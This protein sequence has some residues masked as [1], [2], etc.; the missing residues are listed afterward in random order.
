MRARK[1]QSKTYLYTALLFFLVA[2]AILGLLI[3]KE[4]TGYDVF[5]PYSISGNAFSGEAGRIYEMNIKATY[6]PHWAGVPGRALRDEGGGTLFYTRTLNRSEIIPK[7][8]YTFECLISPS[9]GEREMYASFIQNP[10]WATLV[11]AD[12]ALV[13]A[14]LPDEVGTGNATESANHTFNDTSMSVT[15]GTRTVN[16]IPTVYTYVNNSPDN[17]S[18]FSTGILID[19][20]GNLVFV[21]KLATSHISYDPDED[22]HFQML[23]PVNNFSGVTY[24]L[25][26]DGLDV[27]P[28]GAAEGEF[29]PGLIYGYVNDSVTG[30]P[31][32]NAKVYVDGNWSNTSATGFYNF[33]VLQGTYNF[34]VR[35]M[36]YELLWNYPVNVSQNGTSHNVSINP[37]VPSTPAANASVYG[38]VTDNRTGAVLDNVSISVHGVN[39][40][41]NA[42]GEYNL[43]TEIGV[44]NIIAVLPGYNVYAT[45]V[46]LPIQD[47]S[48]EHNIS[49]QPVPEG[50][51][52]NEGTLNG[53]VY[54]DGTNTTLANVTIRIAGKTNLSNNNG[55]YNFSII[56][57][58]HFVFAQRVGYDDYLAEVTIVA[59]N[60][61]NW[62]INMTTVVVP[63]VGSIWGYVSD[64]E[65]RTLIDNVTVAISTEATTTNAVGYYN[66]TNIT[67]GDYYIIGIADGYLINASWVNI[68]AN[69]ATHFNI[70]LPPFTEPGAGPGAGAGAGPGAG[71]GAGQGL[72]AGLG[73]GLGPGTGIIEKIG[74]DFYV[75]ISQIERKLSQGTF[76][77]ETVSFYNLGS[78]I[79]SV[80]FDISGAVAPYITLDHTSLTVSDNETGE[81]I[82]SLLATGEP[83]LYSGAL[84]V[85]GDGNASIPINLT[86]LPRDKL[87]IQVLLVDL[88]IIHP[89]MNPGDNMRYKV[90]L[91][92]LLTD[93]EYDVHIDYSFRKQGSAAETAVGEDD[94]SIFTFLTLLNEYPLE[95]NMETGDYIFTVKAQYLNLTSTVSTPFKVTLPIYKYAIFGILPLWLLAVIIL[96]LALATYG[97]LE[98]RHLMLAKRRYV[99]SVEYNLLPKPGP[100]SLYMGKIA[101][102]ERKAWFD[103]DQFTTHCIIAGSTGSG[104]SITAQV[105]VEELLLKDTAIIVF[106][107]TAQWSGMLRKLESPQMLS[108]YP[109]HGMRKGDARAFNGNVRAITNARTVIDLPK[110]IKPG[111]IQIFTLNKMDPSQIDLFVA[112]TVRTVFRANFDEAPQLNVLFVYDEVHRLLPRFGGSGEG[113]I[114]IERACREFRKWGLGVMLVSQVLSDFVGEI[115]ANINT[116]VQM[117]TRDEGDLNRIKMKYGEDLLQSLVKSEVGTGMIVNTASNRGNPYFISFRPI[118]H[119]IQR[120]TDEELEKYNTYNEK[121]D[122]IEY[123]IDQ[124]E[125]E[126]IDVFDM[127]LELKLALDK[128]KTGNFNMVDI[129]LESLK[130][131]VED[132]WRR[133]GKTPK[134]REVTLV[135]ESELKAE[136]KK[137][138]EERKKLETEEASTKA[139]AKVEE[140][141]LKFRKMSKKFFTFT[142]GVAVSSL[143]E[144]RDALTSMDDS[145]F[146]DHVTKDKHEVADW[147]RDQLQLPKDAERFRMLII[148]TEIIA[149]LNEIEESKAEV[150]LG[151]AKA[152]PAM[153]K[154][155]AKPAARAAP[156]RKR[157][158]P[159][160]KNHPLIKQMAELMMLLDAMIKKG[161]K[162]EALEIHKKINALY[163]KLPKELKAKVYKYIAAR[164]K[165]LRKK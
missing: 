68:T 42:T 109:K 69:T 114:Q 5:D 128:V 24:Y 142:N 153:A 3:A 19:G 77:E 110:Y 46:S 94:V 112:N 27:C 48:Y 65:S 89:T 7:E 135:K 125:E 41:S 74:I 90:D 8:T 130:P 105:F 120:L 66:I 148:R 45:N 136:L 49:L 85:G 10:D 15:I 132:E 14:Y 106:D 11:A 82:V 40:T 18:T 72:G 154:P 44:H 118:M 162:K 57:G 32:E 38:V 50:E 158:T 80:N 150:T 97:V 21:S 121:I 141:V 119:S 101:E 55:N 129:Y 139:A 43:T 99:V 157:K 47:L 113:F 165:M 13:D 159:D 155:T 71:P 70:S 98:Y 133:L 59:G 16:N 9:A 152:A 102:S 103:M 54:I 1:R 160:F 79:K 108:H 145:I 116:E 51:V 2:G 161:K 33:S 131:R 91:R 75:S 134:K 28:S 83:G 111:E 31:V 17:T 123:H 52:T 78:D 53:T 164:T 87:P 163:S 62:D 96:G 39:G 36:G 67:N 35:A 86:I 56:E 93:I 147:I 81:L 4:Y 6:A 25:Q 63:G 115:K 20:G 151:E 95:D 144:L 92:N 61:T 23:L 127:R 137:A 22:V 30:L 88:E 126:G 143:E 12:P 76:A 124:L 122:D 107:P 37:L 58:T 100:R 140:K 84:E 73:A 146:S 64:A 60:T 156:A 104:K 34:V 117:R 138:M 26:P 29:Y 149:M